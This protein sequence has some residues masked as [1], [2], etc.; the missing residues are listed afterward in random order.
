MLEL[1]RRYT[2]LYVPSD[3]F[4]TEI[5][6]PESFPPNAT[7]SI[8]KPCAFHIA[9]RS[10]EAPPPPTVDGA[11]ADE[12]VLDAP[13]ADYLF[14]AK[15]PIRSE[16]VQ[17]H[18]L[19]WVFVVQVML[20]GVPPM[21]DMYRKCFAA[22]EDLGKETKSGEEAERSFIHP[23][24]LINFLVGV[25]GKNEAMAIGGPW[26]PTL[27]GAHP[28]RDPAV[29]IRTAIRTCRALTGIDLTPCTQW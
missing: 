8:Q 18:L 12:P 20:M 13:D 4:F 15:V 11:D 1:R 23:T 17:V 2:N 25:R 28:D 26:S 5:R 14:S 16:S 27:D 19:I 6:W 22:T 29:L 21:A 24:R 10:V 7:F 9:H 3:F